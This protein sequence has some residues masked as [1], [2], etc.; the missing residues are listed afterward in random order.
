MPTD[1]IA[2][3]FLLR[4]RWRCETLIVNGGGKSIWRAYDQQLQRWVA[5]R[6]LAPPDVEHARDRPRLDRVLSVAATLRHDNVAHL[7][8]A[9]EDDLGTVLV[10]E[11]VNGPSLRELSDQLGPLPP[12]AVAAI[13]IQLAD[14]AADIHAAGVAHRDLAP[15]NVRVTHDGR[16]KILGLG[17]ARLLA[18]GGA[19]PAV[20]IVAGSLYLAPE[21]L[22][23]GASDART[24]VY[25]IGLM[26]WE[27]ATD[28]QPFGAEDA[29]RAVELR[30]EQ[31]IPPLRTGWS[32]A[33]RHLSEAIRTATRRDPDQRWQQARELASA[34]LA[35]YPE[36][37]HLV[38][39][40]LARGS[41]PEP[42]PP[43][44]SLAADTRP[45]ASPSGEESVH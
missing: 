38:L 40:D 4:E 20:G 22:E 9:F 37:P 39:T 27:L 11:L 5:V 19:T 43:V 21:Q 33:P 14:G 12:H 32:S 10:G 18:D 8:D 45:M 7:Y 31:D 16:L 41:L 3:P 23:G 35:P 29:L 36:R 15:D 26:L 13:G 1:P 42:P 2:E 6:I 30:L 25:A 17:D 24:D 34:L 28:A 44:A